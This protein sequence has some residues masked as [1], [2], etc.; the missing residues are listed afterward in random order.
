VVR[1]DQDL[2]LGEQDPTCGDD[3]CYM[4]GGGSTL[5]GGLNC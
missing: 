5:L 2:D 4:E 1:R 3:L